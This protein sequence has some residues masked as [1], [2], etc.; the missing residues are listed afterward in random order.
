VLTPFTLRAGAPPTSPHQ[1]VLGARLGGQVGDT[2]RLTTPRGVQR[3][4]VSGVASTA[5]RVAPTVFVTDTE[6]SAIGGRVDVIGLI[7]RP[8]VTAATLAET[9]RAALP[10]PPENAD[11]AFAGVYAGNGRGQV[12]SPGVAEGRESVIALSSVF[13]GCTLL[14]AVLVIAST[15]GLSVRQRQRD[16]ALLRTIAATPRQVRRMM[17][18]EAA[19]LALLAAGPAI[20]AGLLATHW[21]RGQFVVRGITPP[22][23]TV[24]IS[25]LPPLVAVA[26][27]LLIAVAAAWIASVRASRIRPIEALGEASVEPRRIGVLRL[28]LGAAG[29]AGGVVLSIVSM[30][31]TG[32]SAAGVG[33]AVVATFVTATALL[34]PL[35]IRVAT[36]AAGL[37]LRRVGVCGQLAVAHTAAAARR[38]APVLTALVLAVGLGGSL[39]FLETSIEHRAGQQNRAGL[40]ADDVVTGPGLGPSLAPALRRVP[41]VVAATGIIRA[42]LIDRGDPSTQ[43]TAQGIDTAALNNT[44]DLDV[45]HG[46]LADLAG[47]TVAIDQLTADTLG[48]HM[49][50]TLHA[51]FGDG[52]PA[53]MRVV[54]IYRRGLGFA[55]VT[56][57]AP[58]LR[59]HTAGLDDAVLISTSNPAALTRAVAHLAPSATVVGRR[60]YR[61]VLDSDV[62]QSAWATEVIVGVLL[63]YVVITAVN[64]LISAALGRRRELATLRLAGTTVAQVRRMVRLEQGLLLSIALGISTAVAAATLI[65]MVKGSTGDA[66]PYIPPAGWAAVVGGTILLGYLATMLPTRVVLRAKP[67][68][69]IGVRE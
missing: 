15:V 65:P 12:E 22:D 8:G 50:D 39:W 62:K 58:V 53:N 32:D 25:W 17:V 63:V 29:L 23:F 28:L 4:R 37:V 19:L 24:R 1:V 2:I 68:E 33:V 18:R 47:D 11:G 36:A 3:F 60:G 38:L 5:Q 49:G 44:I 20:G 31:A 48:L 34:A 55:A 6:A 35:I 46:R 61:A 69:A 14:I 27:K 21:L 26:A 40:L 10:I 66:V 30:Q 16:L 57:S 42:S 54:A 13:G 9:V 45:T 59:A 67:V 56:V 52:A 41:G 7:A 43:Y 64:T 51:W